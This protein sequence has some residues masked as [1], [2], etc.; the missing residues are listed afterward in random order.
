MRSQ[1]AQLSSDSRCHVSVH[2]WRIGQTTL[3]PPAYY[4]HEE[5]EPPCVLLNEWAT[6]VTG[7]NSLRTRHSRQDRSIFTS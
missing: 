6:R 1:F 5:S 4:P 3:I 7:M 2:S